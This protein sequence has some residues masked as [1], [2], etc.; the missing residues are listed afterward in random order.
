MLK[1]LQQY[2]LLFVMCC[3]T[4]HLY[5]RVRYT[6]HFLWCIKILMPLRHLP[7]DV[8]HLHKKRD[9]VVT[10]ISEL[11]GM[12]WCSLSNIYHDDL[13]HYN[14]EHEIW[15]FGCDALLSEHISAMTWQELFFSLFSFG[16]TCTWTL[17]YDTPF[18]F[19]T[20]ILILEG[21]P[22]IVTPFGIFYKKQIPNSSRPMKVVRLVKLS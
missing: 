5:W 2:L 20:W 3:H 6:C 14:M 12:I 22:N 9:I 15:L 1:S 21:S 7:F 8:M 13:W 19:L 16:C 4:V 10:V 18:M 11:T 17:I